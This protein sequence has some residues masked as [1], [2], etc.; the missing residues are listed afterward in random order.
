MN[1]N[2]LLLIS[3]I[4]ASFSSGI[5]SAAPE[6]SGK[7]TYE[8]ASFIDSGTTIGAANSHSQGGTFKQEVSARIY[9]DGETEG[10]PYHFELQAYTD[11]KGVGKHASNDPYTQRDPLREAYFDK[12]AD[13]WDLRIGKQQVVWGTADGIKLLDI[14]NPTDFSEMAQN[15]MEDSRIPV[16]MVNAE[17][18]Q[19][20]GS[21]LQFIVSQPREN[22]FSGIDRNINTSVRA[23]NQTTYADSTTDA[24]SRGQ[25]FMLK[26]P[27]AITGYSNGM[28]N[29][30]PDLGGVAGRF[31]GGFGGKSELSAGGMAGFTLDAFEAMTMGG[32]DLKT[33]NGYNMA[34]AM[35]GASMLCASNGTCTVSDSVTNANYNP[36]NGL[37]YHDLPDNFE[38]AVIGVSNLLGV[39]R[40]SVTGKQMLQYGFAPYYNTNLANYD[41]NDVADATFDYMGSTTFKTF[42]AFLNAKSQYKYKMPKDHEVDL[43]ARYRNTL[44]DGTN[45]SLVASY[46]YDKNPIINL[47]WV[48]DQGAALTKT[49][50]TVG[51]NKVITLADSS[52]DGYGGSHDRAPT[53]KFEQTVKRATNIGASFDTSIDTSSLGPVV[54][55]GEAL[56]QNGVYNPV[57]DRSKLAYGDL[58]A[59]LTMEKGDRFKYVIGADVTALTNMM[60]SLQFIQDMNLDFYDGHKD[61]GKYTADYSTMS[62]LNGFN[63]AEKNK[64]FYSLFL[65]KPFGSSGQHRWNNIYMF[66]ENDGNWNRFDIEYSLDDNTV[67]TM[68]VN[69]YWGDKNTQFGQLKDS[70]NLQLG[71][72]YTF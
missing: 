66:E 62:L 21:S 45:Y 56:Y 4:S 63:K 60:V 51:A 19:E 39:D 38:A 36:D 59:A 20:D 33:Q 8:N 17:K 6:I 49:V 24:H 41:A 53:L 58:D 35:W 71:V 18:I 47:S 64:E 26:G 46:N 57:M 27:D 12:K 9:L 32:G 11:S 10:M 22:V 1:K 69:T 28:L 61:T 54:I 23:N 2:K 30:V 7:I 70:S 37:G 13:D 15:Q 31:A 48:D 29:I 55:R 72:K 44:S 65:S 3:L 25:A 68:E 50:S 67:A 52:G 34:Y 16:W 40:D 42:D 5:V 14:V 43:A